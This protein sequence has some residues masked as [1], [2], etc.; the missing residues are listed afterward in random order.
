MGGGGYP[1]HEKLARARAASVHT[2]IINA[3]E[4][5]PWVTADEVLLNECRERVVS[6]MRILATLL[7]APRVV[8]AID[9]RHAVDITAPDFECIRVPPRFPAGSERQ[10]VAIVTGHALGAGRRPMTPASSSS[11]WQRP[12]RYTPPLPRAFP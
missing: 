10:L 4:C 7:G 8:L 12:L 3:V 2:L 5:E 11:M 6:G 1:T 9:P